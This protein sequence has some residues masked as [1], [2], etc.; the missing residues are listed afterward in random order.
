MVNFCAVCSFCRNRFQ[1][2]RQ[3]KHSGRSRILWARCACLQLA[4]RIGGLE[5]VNFLGYVVHE[6]CVTVYI[7]YGIY[8]FGWN[9]RMIGISLAVV[10]AQPRCLPIFFRQ[11]DC[12]ARLGERR[13]LLTGLACATAG[14][15]MFGWTS[16]VI[17]LAGIPVN[18][19][20]DAG[21][22]TSRKTLMTRRVSSSEQGGI[23]R[24]AGFRCAAICNVDRA[25]TVFAGLCLLHF[26]GTLFCPLRPGIWQRF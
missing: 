20:C 16:S 18:A 5:T 7:L 8:R 25:G 12:A 23:A 24:R 3:I 22:I 9:P 17:F 6:I 14:F 13:S 10:G 2:E 4:C 11:A 1:V 26:A 15:A 19:L 21:R